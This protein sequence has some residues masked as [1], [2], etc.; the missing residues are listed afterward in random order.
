[1]M[2]VRVGA[3]KQAQAPA[4][5]AAAKS[6]LDG[7]PRSELD[8]LNGAFRTYPLLKQSKEKFEYDPVKLAR[9]EGTVSSPPSTIALGERCDEWPNGQSECAS[10]LS[11]AITRH[12]PFRSPLVV[13]DYLRRTA[14]NGP[15]AMLGGVDQD[16]LR[17]LPSGG[18]IFGASEEDCQ[19]AAAAG[20]ARS[21]RSVVCVPGRSVDWDGASNE[22]RTWYVHDALVDAFLP[23]SQGRDSKVPPAVRFIRLLD[24]LTSGRN[25]STTVHIGIDGYS[26]RVN[27][28]LMLSSLKPWRP[29]VTRL[30]FDESRSSEQQ[31]VAA[32]PTGAAKVPTAAAGGSGTHRVQGGQ[33]KLKLL[34]DLVQPR[35]VVSPRGGPVAMPGSRQLH[36]VGW[37][38]W[39]VWHLVTVQVKPRRE[40][41]VRARASRQNSRGR[42]RR[43]AIDDP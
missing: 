2:H 23:A 38:R 15:I 22:V 42:G 3:S 18:R 6:S 31:P 30:A 8:L 36:H 43:S 12:Y 27:M 33:G 26:V 17:C 21:T 32:E 28:R 19:H 24:K 25:E 34:E 16:L 14:T 1:M 10:N 39:G 35:L 20:S 37:R 4:L 9:R 40:G 13:A 41:A 11:A 29:T 5:S 7:P